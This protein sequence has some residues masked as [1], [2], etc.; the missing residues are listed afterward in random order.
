MISETTT[1]T[2]G[3]DG[4]T[5][6]TTTGTLGTVPVV[7]TT[8]VTTNGE[9]VRELVYVPVTPGAGSA[10]ATPTVLP[11]LYEEVPGSASNTTVSLPAGVGLVSVGDRTPTGSTG[12]QG[13]IKMIQSTVS[14]SDPTRTDM[15][16]GGQ[17]FLDTLPANSTLWVNKIQLTAPTALPS[18][19]SAPVVVNGAANNASSNFTGD[20]LEALVIDASALPAGTVVELQN[21]DFAVVIGNGVVVRGGSGS[22]VVYGGAGTQNIMLGEADDVLYGGAGDDIVGSEGGADQIFGN[23]GNDTLFGGAGADILHGGSGID[24]VTYAGNRSRYEI[25]RDHGKTIVRSLD[26]LD[27]IDTLIN[28]ET[29]RFGDGV[30]QVQNDA[31]HTWIATLYQ[32]VF[33]RQPDLGGFQYW[34]NE[35]ARGDTLGHIAMSFLHSAEYASGMGKAFDQL[36][37]GQQIDLF[38]QHFLGR[39]A[40][41]A[42]HAYWVGRLN[43]GMSYEDI[44]HSFV[45][46]LEMQQSYRQPDAWEFLL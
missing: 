2:T 46:S 5:T 20:K 10:S 32:Q 3:T 13:L 31:F 17:S 45:V 11:L 1:T 12:Q 26:R 38:Y 4:T 19:P 25:V 23:S 9:T 43:E 15:V 42:G 35:Y 44:A 27:D 6:T 14:E 24:V 30:V 41:P 37:A 22:N 16:G 28:V 29:I 34:A 8:T 36:T 40:E 33:N 7:E 39:E 18:S 21:V